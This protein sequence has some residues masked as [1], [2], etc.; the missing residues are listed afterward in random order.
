[1]TPTRHGRRARWIALGTAAA[2]ATVAACAD[3]NVPFFTAPTS[4]PNSP[5]GIQNAVSGL[6]SA[7]RFDF[8]DFITEVGAGY[9]RDGS[10]FTNTE[11]RTVEYPL[12]VFPEPSTWAG[13]WANEYQNIYQAHATLATIAKVSPAYTAAQ[14]AAL[15]GVLQTIEAINYMIVAEAHD[16]LGIDIQAYPPVTSL[17]PAVCVKNAWQYITALLDSADA[18]LETAGAIPLPIKFPTGFAGVSNAA[19]PG[20]TLG[21]FA[22]FNR[23]L[24]AKAYLELAYAIARTPSGGPNAPTDS[25]SGLPDQTQ[26]ATALAD[27]NASGMWDPSGASLV[28]NAAGA[29]SADSR[30]VMW[31]F[32]AQSGDQVNAIQQ[33]IG[34]IAQLR[35]FV[36]DVDTLH[37]LRWKAKFIVN[38]VITGGGAVQQQL[39]NPVASQY[40]YAMS[41]SPGSPIPLMRE[42]T[43]TLWA[44]Q[45]QLGMGNLTQALTYINNVRTAVGGPGLAPYPAS[46]ATSGLPTPY[47][48]VRNDLMREQRISTTWEFSLDRTITI[49]MYGM[50]AASDTTW[51]VAGVLPHGGTEDPAVTV[52]DSHTTVEPI[53]ST[54]IAGRGGAYTPSC[55]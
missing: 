15:T 42:E 52:T 40:L 25:T 35:D 54:E 1:M 45:I 47:Q 5:A 51:G 43:M 50:A 11:A 21:T 33:Q 26:L 22:S 16:T 34:T 8:G 36:S 55:N 46:D 44:A 27:L 41:L 24:A 23:A 10:V 32:S 3:S 28:P 31:D 30:N 12:G 4:V 9:S 38:P 48:K 20:A 49:R 17:P 53:P 7:S 37:D 19:G 14:A 18:S 13:D 29:F 6:F 2:V 39:Y